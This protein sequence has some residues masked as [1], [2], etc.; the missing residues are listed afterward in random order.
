MP[1]ATFLGAVHLLFTKCE[2]QIQTSL[3]PSLVPPNQEAINPLGVCAMVAAW[4]S[5]NEAVSKMNS[6]T[7]IPFLKDGFCACK[8]NEQEAMHSIN[9]I[10]AFIYW[11]IE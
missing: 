5:G 11:L 3:L 4:L 7:R 9:N 8:F 2:V 1:S 6:S 10:L